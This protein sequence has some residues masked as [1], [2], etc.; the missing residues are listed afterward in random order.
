MQRTARKKKNLKIYD[1]S[2]V[3]RGD[4]SNFIT[5][6]AIANWKAKRRY[7]EGRPQLYS[8]DC[9]VAILKLRYA[10]NLSLRRAHG[11]VE[12]IFREL[13]IELE[14]PHYSTVCK[15]QVSLDIP[16]IRK[17]AKKLGNLRGHW[18]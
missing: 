16:L 18:I 2:L 13:N 9:V 1:R 4:I 17:Q 15:R 12:S 11:M 7:R 10:F 3:K 8:D 14:I 5:P 6:Q